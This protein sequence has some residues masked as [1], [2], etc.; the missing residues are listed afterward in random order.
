LCIAPSSASS[1]RSKCSLCR[2]A[3]VG[4]GGTFRLVA[5]SLFAICTN[6]TLGHRSKA[7]KQAAGQVLENNLSLGA[8]PSESSLPSHIGFRSSGFGSAMSPNG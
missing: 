3:E 1:E 7:R 2:K 8:R 4:A 6:A 5:A